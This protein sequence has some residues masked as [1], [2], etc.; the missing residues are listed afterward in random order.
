MKTRKFVVLFPAMFAMVAM[1]VSCNCVGLATEPLKPQETF[2]FIDT[3]IIKTI[4]NKKICLKPLLEIDQ[5]TKCFVAVNCDTGKPNIKGRKTVEEL[6][7]VKYIEVPGSPCNSFTADVPGNTNYYCS[8]GY[9][10]PY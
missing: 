1:L 8:G 2:T 9:C 3:Q 6:F 5:K 7:G 10:Y 4:D